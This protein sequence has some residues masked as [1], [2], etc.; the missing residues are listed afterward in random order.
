MLKFLRT[1]PR[2][3]Y[4]PITFPTMRTM[5]SGREFRHAL[6]SCYMSR[7]PPPPAPPQPYEK[8]L[9]LPKALENLYV[10]NFSMESLCFG[11]LTRSLVQSLRATKQ[12]R[13]NGKPFCQALWDGAFLSV[14][15][16]ISQIWSSVY[17]TR[18]DGLYSV[19]ESPK[20]E[21]QHYE[22]VVLN[23]RVHR[24]NLGVLLNA[25][26]DAVQQVCVQGLRLCTSSELLD[27]AGDAG[28]W[29]TLSERGQLTLCIKPGFQQLY[30]CLHLTL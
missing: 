13:T 29:T 2:I 3:R 1:D 26:S 10:I 22:R 16:E 8:F 15:L 18:E 6:L 11:S 4:I 12:V 28:P 27:A 30:Q 23:L 19:G 17:V 9:M 25:Y 14:Q 5:R 20:G 21:K 24:Y 7:F